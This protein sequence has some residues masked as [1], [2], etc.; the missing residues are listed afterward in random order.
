MS[1]SRT[2]RRWISGFSAL[3]Q[4]EAD[5]VMMVVSLGTWCSA[6]IGRLTLWVL[7]ILSPD[8]AHQW[9]L[10]RRDPVFWACGVTPQAADAFRC[11][12]L[13]LAMPGA[14]VYYR[15]LMKL[16]TYKGGRYFALLPVNLIYLLS[17][18]F[19]ETLALYE[20]VKQGYCCYSRYCTCGETL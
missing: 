2:I 8:F 10:K 3:F 17:F 20:S 13:H 5:A 7:K 4:P 1:P 9:E 6:H 12:F 11:S 16:I 15:C 18:L 19:K 14:Y